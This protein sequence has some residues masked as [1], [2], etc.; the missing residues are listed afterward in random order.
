MI[1]LCTQLFKKCYTSMQ[2][3]F[4]QYVATKQ[5]LTA[6]EMLF[7]TTLHH[8]PRSVSNLWPWIQS[9][10]HGYA[11]VRQQQSRKIYHCQQLCVKVSDKRRCDGKCRLIN[12]ISN[13]NFSLEINSVSDGPLV[14]RGH[15]P[16]LS[17]CA[18]FPAKSHYPFI[19]TFIWQESR[20]GAS[21]ASLK[22]NK[23]Q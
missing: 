13:N 2:Q 15:S 20:E 18:R 8:N 17:D 10:F 1:N 9:Q 22:I 12:N 19:S 3:F 14:G 4:L 11:A 7:V 23:R 21:R 5:N 6:S 16:P